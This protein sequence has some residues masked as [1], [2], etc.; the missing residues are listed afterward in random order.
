MYGI[1][2]YIWLIFYGK[3]GYIN[4]PYMDPMGCPILTPFS[5]LKLGCFFFTML[6]ESSQAM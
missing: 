6:G 1:F 2:A 3:C 4:I 5:A